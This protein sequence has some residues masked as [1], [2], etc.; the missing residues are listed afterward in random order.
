[1]LTSSAPSKIGSCRRPAFKPDFVLISA[2]FDGMRRDVLGRFDVT[3]QGFAAITG[4]VVSL[5]SQLCQGRI[6]SLPGADIG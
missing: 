6:V 2:G 3:P 5:A 1:M 4:V